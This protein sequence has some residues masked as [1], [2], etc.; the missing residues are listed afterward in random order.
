MSDNTVQHSVCCSLLDVLVRLVPGCALS[1]LLVGLTNASEVNAWLPSI[2]AGV[3]GWAYWMRSAQLHFSALSVY[4]VTK[5][6]SSVSS[7]PTE[8]WG[9]YRENT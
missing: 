3:D 6:G 5:A 8:A 9:R 4:E 7:H 2:A 1:R